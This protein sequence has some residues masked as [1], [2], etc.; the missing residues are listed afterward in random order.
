MISEFVMRHVCVI[1]PDFL[2]A[3]LKL[4][5]K[6]KRSCTDNGCPIIDLSDL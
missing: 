3:T 1:N 2:S 5:K 4:C 6:C